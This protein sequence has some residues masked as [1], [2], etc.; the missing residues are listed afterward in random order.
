MRKLYSVERR[1]GLGN[2]LRSPIL[3]IAGTCVITEFQ[4]F[5]RRMRGNGFRA[6]VHSPQQMSAVLERAG[7]VY[8]ATQGTL[9]CVVDLYRR[10]GDIPDIV[11]AG[12]GQHNSAACSVLQRDK[13]TARP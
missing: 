2:C 3:A 4:N 5:L 8:A 6:F 13:N 9:V 11:D 10:M 1:P 12:D 7:L